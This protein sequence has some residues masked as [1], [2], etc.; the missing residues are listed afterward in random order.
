MHD[1]KAILYYI[2]KLLLLLTFLFIFDYS[3]Y[4]KNYKNMIYFTMIYFINKKNLNITY[5]FTHL[6]NILNKIN[7]QI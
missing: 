7:N 3:S 5:N 1:I 2:S 4:S 6:N